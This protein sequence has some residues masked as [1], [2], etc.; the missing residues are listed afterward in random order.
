MAL[1]LLTALKRNK[2]RRY[3]STVVVANI[4]Y[5]LSRMKNRQFALEKIRKL[6]ELVSIAPLTEGMIDAAVASPH[7]DFEDSIQLHCA[8][9]NGIKVLIT[10]NAGD[11]PKGR[12]RL[13]DPGQ[14]LAGVRAE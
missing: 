5:L 6:R 9:T 10:R 4:Y 8:V 3:T 13:A 7:K 12:I 2:I 1:R 14:Y 11:Y